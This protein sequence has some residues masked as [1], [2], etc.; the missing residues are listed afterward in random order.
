MGRFYNFLFY[1]ENK[2]NDSLN[3]LFLEFNKKV[4]IDRNDSDK[5][6]LV[7]YNESCP[8]EIYQLIKDHVSGI[9]IEADSEFVKTIN[10]NKSQLESIYNFYKLI[11]E[12]FTEREIPLTEHVSYYY[13]FFNRFYYTLS[14]KRK[15][16]KIFR[17]Y[18]EKD[19]KDTDEEVYFDSD[20]M[21]AYDKGIVVPK[22]YKDELDEILRIINDSKK[23]ILKNIEEQSSNLERAKD[24]EKSIE[25][26]I[27]EILKLQEELEQIT[28][29]TTRIA[30]EEEAFFEEIDGVKCIK[31]C[32]HPYLRFLDLKDFYFD[33]VYIAGLNFSYCNAKINPQKV[34]NRDLSNCIFAANSDEE[35]IFSDFTDFKGCKVDGM[36]IDNAPLSLG[37][38]LESNKKY[39]NN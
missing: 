21:E 32:W 30:I 35:R 24:I 22:K 14:L 8:S 23:E 7:F 3:A 34:Y 36:Y 2:L 18:S 15:K 39:L 33:D 13:D 27:L 5:N 37:V 29:T 28:K 9:S 17:Y 20:F 4:K 16:I 31:D 25:E 19:Y 1:G 38:T 10:E 12:N 11:V 26:R 6:C